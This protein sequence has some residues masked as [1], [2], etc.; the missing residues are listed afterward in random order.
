MSQS[1]SSIKQKTQQ[2]IYNNV[3]KE[4]LI[5]R[6]KKQVGVKSLKH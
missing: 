2:G 1:Q 3:I 5:S 6:I 4:E